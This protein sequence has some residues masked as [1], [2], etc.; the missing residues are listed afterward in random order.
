[1]VFEEVQADLENEGYK[2]QSFLLPACSVGA[3]HR[4]DRVWFIA[5]RDNGLSEQQEEK[6]QSR[7]EAAIDG[8][9]PT[10]TDTNGDG[11]QRGKDNGSVEK[12]RTLR[13]QQSTR[14]LPPTWKDFPTQPFICGRNDGL[15]TKLDNIT[16]SKWRSESIKGFGNAIVPELAHQIFKSIQQYVDITEEEEM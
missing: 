4:R 2:V 9:K 1:M 16:V 14:F 11:L 13:K 15:P 12:I 5:Y 6:I 8:N 10:D 7:R 3:P